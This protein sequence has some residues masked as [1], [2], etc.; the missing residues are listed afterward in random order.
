MYRLYVRQSLPFETICDLLELKKLDVVKALEKEMDDEEL[1]EVLKSVY[2]KASETLKGN[3]LVEKIAEQL[4]LEYEK[5]KDAEAN[6]Y[7]PELST[8]FLEIHPCPA[9][10]GVGW[11]VLFMYRRDCELCEGKCEVDGAVLREYTE[12]NPDS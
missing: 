9:C 6:V 11:T 1:N 5:P 10:E 3:D 12:A 2:S 8:D 4:G 7:S